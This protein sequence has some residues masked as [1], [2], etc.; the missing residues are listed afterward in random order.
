MSS[1]AILMTTVARRADARKLAKMAVQK[2]LA[3]C[4][5]VIGGVRST[6]RWKG[7]IEESAE[8]L[9]LFKT[10]KKALPGLIKAIKATHPY[11]LPEIVVVPVTGGS[12]EYLDWVLAE[13][14]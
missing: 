6:Y 3:A 11:S 10:T 1:C 2:R 12:R 14:R 13:T 4:V 5:Q 9:M 8:I 7:K